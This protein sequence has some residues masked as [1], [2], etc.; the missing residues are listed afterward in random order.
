M[1]NI[2]PRAKLIA[3]SALL[4]RLMFLAIKYVK[5]VHYFIAPWQVPLPMMRGHHHHI[6]RVMASRLA[7]CLKPGGQIILMTLRKTHEMSGHEAEM[8]RQATSRYPPR[9]SGVSSNF[10]AAD[11][12]CFKAMHY[13][14]SRL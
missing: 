14:R 8:S 10:A 11:A 12:I 1:R 3:S 5:S 9:M 13:F 6:G 7:E 2:C 4:L